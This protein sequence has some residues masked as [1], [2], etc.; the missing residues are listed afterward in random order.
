MELYLKINLPGGKRVR[1][2]DGKTL[3]K[4]KGS[5]F[6]LYPDRAVI[7][8]DQIGH[9]LL[10]QDPH[11]VSELPAADVPVADVTANTEKLA[12]LHEIAE[13]KIDEMK[14]NDIIEYGKKL[15]ITIPQSAK[16]EMKIAMLERRCAEVAKGL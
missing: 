5:E 3:E 2:I 13:Q 15:G 12:I 8:P 4:I 10:K 14:A 9:Q 16:R 7:V 6:M 1:L 11:L